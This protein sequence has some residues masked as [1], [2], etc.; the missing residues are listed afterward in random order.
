MS[1]R[2]ILVTDALIYANGPVHLGHMLG[3]VQTDIWSRFQNLRGHECHYVCGAD[4]HG[5]PIMLK[6]EQLKQSPDQMVADIS[7]QQLT[8][9]QD[10]GVVFASFELSNIAENQALTTQAYAKLQANGDIETRTIKQAFDEEKQMFLPDRYVKGTCPCCGAEGQYSDSCEACGSTYDGTGGIKN[11]IS[12][13]SG[14]PPI[15]KDSEHFFFKLGHYQEFLK[16]WT[17]PEHLQSEVANK[18]QEWFKEGLQDWDISRDAPYYGFE[19]PGAP[20]K[21]FYVWLDAPF[22]YLASFQK[23]C[24]RTGLNFNEFWNPDSTTELHHSIGKDITYFHALFW[25]A[26]LRGAGFRTP[27]KVHTHGYL[28]INGQKMSKSRGTF[29]TARQ[30][31]DQGLSPDY[32]RYYFAAKLNSNV[33]DIDIN[34]E[35]FR[36]RVNADLVGKVVNIASRCAGFIQKRFDNKLANQMAEPELFQQFAQAH[37]QIAEHYETREFGRAM[38][39][40]MALADRANQFVEQYKPWELAKSPDKQSEVQQVCTTG[41]NLFKQLIT[42]LKPVLPYTSLG[43]EEFL[44]AGELDWASIQTPLLNHTLQPF[45]PL[46]MRVEEEKIAGLVVPAT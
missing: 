19:V 45:K 33:E 13:L 26:I 36:L 40:I 15:Y 38:R 16:N 7:A 12:V 27:S 30:Y 6:A 10:F 41:I 8:D 31:L 21:F 37:V 46:M 35:D 39:E 29:I 28:T 24:E 44:N 25:P 20:G 34:F 23:L 17:T 11:P 14:K 4:T 43:A 18:L 32:M 42:Y 5:T 9:F 3:Y 22:G 1:H 2:K